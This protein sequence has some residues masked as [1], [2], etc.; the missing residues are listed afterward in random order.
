MKKLQ[1]NKE[2][3]QEEYLE[4]EDMEYFFHGKKLSA[5]QRGIVLIGYS[6]KDILPFSKILKEKNCFE[7]KNPI[8]S[9]DPA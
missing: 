5:T 7:F 8:S 1:L 9:F 6:E 3:S 2:G 4:E